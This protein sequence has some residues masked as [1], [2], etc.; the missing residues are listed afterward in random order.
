MKTP[1]KLYIDIETSPSLGYFFELYKEG[2]ILATTKS[3]YILSIAWKFEG[4]KQVKCLGLVDYPRYKKDREDD[5]DLV[6]DIWELLN[7][8]DIVLAHNGDRFDIKKINARFLKH[9]LTPPSPYKTIDTLKIARNKFAMDSNKLDSIAK[10][11]GVGSKLPH[12]GFKL[13]QDCMSGD[14]KAWD[15]MKKYNK[16][17]VVL[18]E[19]VYEALKPWM[20]TGPNMNVYMG[21]THNCPKCGEDALQRRGE[22]YTK[23]QKYQRFQCQEC[24]SWCSGDREPIMKIAVK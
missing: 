14:L 18:L 12:T 7:S 24:Y 23:T 19:H 8:A 20:T 9:E 21:T 4:E 5:K 2:N 22:A 16:Q 13:W 1:K 11:L 15:L 3:W 6:E 10:Y 17:D